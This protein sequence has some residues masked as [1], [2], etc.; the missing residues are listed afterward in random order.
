MASKAAPT[1]TAI[2]R[3]NSI[4]SSLG[5]IAPLNTPTRRFYGSQDQGLGHTPGVPN[6]NIYVVQPFKNASIPKDLVYAKK[7]APN[8]GE[9]LL[10]STMELINHFTSCYEAVKHQLQDEHIKG[11]ESLLNSRPLTVSGTHD[12][13]STSVLHRPAKQARLRPLILHQNQ[14][15]REDNQGPFI[16]DCVG[17]SPV[18]ETKVDDLTKIY[19]EKL[20]LLRTLKP[21]LFDSQAMLQTSEPSSKKSAASSF[22]TPHN[23]LLTYENIPFDE[24]RTFLTEFTNEEEDNEINEDGKKTI[25]LASLQPTNSL[26]EIMK[27]NYV[28][29]VLE[30]KTMTNTSS[31]RDRTKSA[32]DKGSYYSHKGNAT[33]KS[34]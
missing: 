29:K 14:Q 20:R 26:N 28:L 5:T 2:R 12:T 1:A 33:A 15:S 31:K 32:S 7:N 8:P 27:N 22:R 34:T 30:I 4:H 24:R 10:N 18:P 6:P 19:D 3:G 25:S 17:I 16:Q 23:T 21:E 13:V 9:A 11:R